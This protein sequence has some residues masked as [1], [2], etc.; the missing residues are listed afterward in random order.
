MQKRIVRS[1]PQTP[2]DC[3]R[4]TIVEVKADTTTETPAPNDE[5]N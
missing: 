2:G 4:F 1:N 5:T 3:P